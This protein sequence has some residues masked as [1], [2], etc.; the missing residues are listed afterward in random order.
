MN[1]D[2][3]SPPAATAKLHFVRCSKETIARSHQAF[4]VAIH[5]TFEISIERF[6][7]PERPE[8]DVKRLHELIH[9][10]ISVATLDSGRTSGKSGRNQLSHLGG[11]RTNPKLPPTVAI[12]SIAG[13][14]ARST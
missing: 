4:V 3:T 13:S 10:G 14:H 8:R 11:P 5:V 1:L 2:D 9:V 7:P 6:T 12:I